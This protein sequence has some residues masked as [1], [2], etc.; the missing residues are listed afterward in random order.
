VPE[1]VAPEPDPYTEGWEPLSGRLVW[2]TEG[3][4]RGQFSWPRGIAVSDDGF[5]YVADSHNHRIQK[6]T[7]D[8]QF[9]TA[10][11]T[12]GN[13]GELV[14]APGTFCEPWDVT[15]DSDGSVYVADTWGHRVQKF[16]A[17]GV[18]L[19]EWG[20]FGQYSVG[21]AGYFYG[22]RAVA[23]GPDEAVYVVDT[24]NKRVQ[25]FS[26]DG[27]YLDQWGGPGAAPGQLDEPV[28][29]AFGPDGRAYL[30]DSWNVRVQVL[31][32]DGEPVE[33]WPIAGWN[34]PSVDEKPYLAVDSDERVYVTDPGHYRVLVFDG[35]GTFLHSFGQFGF[36]A[37][38]FS[39]P[40]G[41]ALGPD[42]SLYVTDAAGHRVLVFDLPR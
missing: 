8:G 9:V 27:D 20:A 39:L 38:S 1:A 28:G 11:G 3:S 24:G 41:V 21:G 30:A 10:W 22:P 12:Y 26:P 5:V 13:C 37:A 32:P 42:D 17:D 36:D 2:G 29:L 14:P 23:V 6:F 35:E 40:M 15:V 4:G 34:N 31:E 7:A 18:F 25:V 16:T 19:T 33:S